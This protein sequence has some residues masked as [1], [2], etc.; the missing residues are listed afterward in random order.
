MNPSVMNFCHGNYG[1]TIGLDINL[2]CRK[3]EQ[4][5]EKMAAMLAERLYEEGSFHRVIR[6]L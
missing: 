4:H 6:G 3:M 1:F 2:R 5:M